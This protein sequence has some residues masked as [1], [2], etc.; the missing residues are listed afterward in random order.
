M[1]ELRRLYTVKSD[2]ISKNGAGTRRHSLFLPSVCEA[3]VRLIR[4]G[5]AVTPSRLRARSGRGSDSPL[6][7]HSLPRP[8]FATQ[9]G[10]VKTEDG[11][12]K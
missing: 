6:D 11:T 10:K 8:R 5:A 12:V 2:K 4:H 7:C 9:Q 3:I 1:S